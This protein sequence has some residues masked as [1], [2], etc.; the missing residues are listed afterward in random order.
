MT[1]PISGVNPQQASFTKTFQPEGN[2]QQERVARS[3]E[4]IKTG[5]QERIQVRGTATSQN[6]LIEETREKQESDDKKA[7]ARN[8][9]FA[10]NSNSNTTQRRGSLVDVVV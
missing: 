10:A 9:N 8:Q 1:G 7:E 5:E 4:E 3:G 2:E 6:K